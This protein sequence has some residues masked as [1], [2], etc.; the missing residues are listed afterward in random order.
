MMVDEATTL[1]E[2]TNRR[3][4]P[5]SIS[6]REREIRGLSSIFSAAR[7]YSSGWIGQVILIGWKCSVRA[8]Q[9]FKFSFCYTWFHLGSW[10]YT[11][12]IYKAGISL[13]GCTTGFNP[14]FL[15]VWLQTKIKKLSLL[16]YLPIAERKIVGFLFF[17]R[18]LALREMQKASFRIWTRVATNRNRL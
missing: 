10:C 16:Y 13:S 8:K 9:K 4:F 3:P 11:Y 14:V 2:Q 17:L 1:R 7:K 15:F 18:L 6:V 5:L 12:G